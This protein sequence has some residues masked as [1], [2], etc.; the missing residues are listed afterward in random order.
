MNT[1]MSYRVQY[2]IVAVILWAGY[3]V[4]GCQQQAISGA[5]EQATIVI[6]V[7]KTSQNVVLQE[8]QESSRQANDTWYKAIL[9][10]Q[11]QNP[12]YYTVANTIVRSSIIAM[13]LKKTCNLM[14]SGFLDSDYILPCAAQLCLVAM[15]LLAIQDM[16]TRVSL[17][18]LAV[19]YR[20][21]QELERQ[22]DA[23]IDQEQNRMHT[24]INQDNHTIA[25]RQKCLEQAIKADHHAQG[26]HCPDCQDPQCASESQDNRVKNDGDAI[27]NI[28]V[29]Q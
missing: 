27:V 19:G 28:T 7:D 17:E 12:W 3:A 24:I 2:S 10:K 26:D 11:L 25:M 21:H 29:N 1:Y 22:K 5:C 20:E 13:V 18:A 23:E 16:D 4:S 14:G 6:N 15:V 9:A 8:Q